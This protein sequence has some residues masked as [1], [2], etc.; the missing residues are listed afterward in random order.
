MPATSRIR[1]HGATKDM[2]PKTGAVIFQQGARGMRYHDIEA[3]L[4]EL[5]IWGKENPGRYGY[6][7]SP[8]TFKIGAELNAKLKELAHAVSVFQQGMCVIERDV[9]DPWN[10]ISATANSIITRSRDGLPRCSGAPVPLCKVDVVIDCDLHP[11]IV[12]IDAYNPRGIPYAACL[13]H[14]QRTLLPEVGG[15]KGVLDYLVE[16]F[17]HRQAAR[18]LW[19]YA[20][21]ERYYKPWFQALQALLRHH[22]MDLVVC[23]AGSLTQRDIDE[24][25]LIIMVPVNMRHIAE[26]SARGLLTEAYKKDPGRFLYPMVPWLGSKS[27]LALATNPTNHPEIDA[28]VAGRVR[29]RRLVRTYIPRTVLVSKYFRGDTGILTSNGKTVLKETMSSGMKGVWAS[30]HATYK[31]KLEAHLRNKRPAAILQDL[32]PQRIF[33]LPYYKDPNTVV[34]DNWYVRLTAYISGKGELVDAEVTAR[35]TPDVHGAPDCLM[36][37]CSLQ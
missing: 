29:K 33:G 32:V 2:Y 26:K 8:A 35:R 27:L 28:L 31:E 21:Y 11:W 3:A 15:Y 5:G 17:A 36:L 19:V 30:T 6:V 14:F 1:G 16:E 25:D 34:K 10:D 24:S 4:R 13:W 23:G 12:E 7:L 18:I 20:E 9:I 22:D 37:P